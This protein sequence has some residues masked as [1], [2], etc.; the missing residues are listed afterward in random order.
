MLCEKILTF[1]EHLDSPSLARRALDTLRNNPKRT[2][3]QGLSQLVQLS[4]VAIATVFQDL[5]SQFPIIQAH[6]YSQKKN[7]PL[8]PS[9]T[10]TPL[11]NEKREKNPNRSFSPFEDSHTLPSSGLAS[12]QHTRK[13]VLLSESKNKAPYPSRP[14]QPRR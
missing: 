6:T 12:N 10:Y 5:S 13:G 1:A 14:V 11:P 4:K 2:L 9:V 7:E 3:S 8:A